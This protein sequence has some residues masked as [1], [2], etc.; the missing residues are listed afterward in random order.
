[1]S[2]TPGPPDSA[3]APAAS[4][5]PHEIVVYARPGCPYCLTLRAGLR[6]AGLSF[7]AVNIWEDERAAAF[8]RSVAKGNETVPTVTLGDL[9]MVNPSARNVRKRAE[10][11]TTRTTDRRRR[12]FHRAAQTGNL[13]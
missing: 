3:D 1:M 7:R 2:A 9:A 4:T 12:W 5:S 11:T 8:V 6:R 13:K 10:L